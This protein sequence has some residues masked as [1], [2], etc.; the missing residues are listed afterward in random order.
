[1]ACLYALNCSKENKAFMWYL[2]SQDQVLLKLRRNNDG[3]GYSHTYD[4]MV[5]T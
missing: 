1:M 4:S 2:R 5:P 3:G